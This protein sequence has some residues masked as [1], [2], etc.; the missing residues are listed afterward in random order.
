V[1][2]SIFRFADFELDQGA[3][4]LRQGG[5]TLSIERIPLDLLFLLVERRGRLVTR[6]EILRRVWGEGV[7]VDS[8]NA[9]NT[10]VRKLR[11]A[12]KDDSKKP[13]FVATVPT[14]GYRFVG[15][16][17]GD[18]A[19]AEGEKAASTHADNAS[20][21]SGGSIVGREDELSQLD[22]YFERA[23][24]GTRQILFVTGEPGIGKTALVQSFLSSLGDENNVRVAR[25]QCIQ[26]YGSGEPYMPVL[27]ALT[28]LCRRV[29][30]EHL[31]EILNQAAPSWL[32]QMPSLLNDSDRERLKGVTQGVTHQRMLREIA[33]ALEAMTAE[34]PLVLAFE[35]LHWSDSST[36]EFIATVARRSEAARLLIIGTYRPVEILANGHPLRAVKEELELQRRC[37]EMKIKLLGEQDVAAY[38]ALRFA[39]DQSSAKLAQVI[40]Q[41]TE[42]NPLFMVNVTDYLDESG[43]LRS[44]GRIEAP[45]TIQQMIQRNLERLDCEEQ[46][47]LEAASVVGVVFSAAEVAAALERPVTEIETCCTVLVRREQFIDANSATIWTNGPVANFHFQHALYS[48]VLYARVPPTH[49]VQLHQRIAEYLETAYGEHANQIASE[50]A[51]HYRSAKDTNK[52]IQYLACASEQAVGRAANADA[53]ANLSEALHLLNSIQDDSDRNAT[54]IRLQIMLGG[55]LTAL[56]GFAAPEVKRAYSRAH[57]LC[58]GLSDPFQ[59]PALYGL[60]VYYLTK[61]EIGVAKELAASQF[62]RLAQNVQDRGLILQAHLMLGGTLHHFGDFATARLHLDQCLALH[63]PQIH[64]HHA[65]IYGQDPGTIGRIY[66]GL[67]LWYLGFPDQA[68]KKLNEALSLAS[69]LQYPLTSAFAN[70]FA[71][72]LHQALGEVEASDARAEAA[73]ALASEHGFPLP[74]GMG[75][76]FRGWALAEQGYPDKGIEQIQQGREICEASGAAL[77]RPYFLMLLAEAYRKGSRMTEGH[78]TLVEALVSI[79]NNGERAYEADI[80]RLQAE[81]LLADGANGEDEAERKLLSAISLAR[82]QNA[83][84]LEL[85]ATSTLARVLRMQGRREEARTMLAEIYHW[86]TE[87][88]DTAALIEAGSLLKELT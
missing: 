57:E 34:V 49:R 80:L 55:A 37:G 35:D 83:K 85:R 25:G 19:R 15:V 68:L 38:L 42:G 76:I 61:G 7:F 16:V 64:R 58:K 53:V 45:P 60:W 23:K 5:V 26:Q 69:E 78:A 48:D 88:F 17:V 52:A 47:T 79:K 14:K 74:F 72:W 8:G 46:E 77:I 67:V 62:L 21:R 44:R 54:E 22:K 31:I 82:L 12:L 81:F 73:I 9:V 43:S 41:R 32:V 33:E 6:T 75:K 84:S 70:G 51:H 4:A 87:G 40:H 13:K 66:A 28:R 18:R 2:S 24:A 36:L 59:L 27:E 65:F 1:Q 20:A 56:K 3:Y 29:G 86:F 11:S 50:L 30:G 71:A 63:D 10:A 39:G